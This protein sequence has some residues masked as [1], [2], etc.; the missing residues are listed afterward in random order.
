MIRGVNTI[1]RII[2][3]ESDSRI[4]E[5]VKRSIPHPP[6]KNKSILSRA[7][8]MFVNVI[9]IDIL[10]APKYFLTVGLSQKYTRNNGNIHQKL[11]RQI[12]INNNLVQFLPFRK[13]NNRKLSNGKITK[14]AVNFPLTNSPAPKNKIVALHP[15]AVTSFGLIFSVSVF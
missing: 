5:T 1:E 13:P 9:L 6:I 14:I 3:P 7:R 15:I 4:K 10:S 12:P 11:I 8:I 2:A